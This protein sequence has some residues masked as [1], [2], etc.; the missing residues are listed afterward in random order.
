MLLMSVGVIVA[1]A[2]P[3]GATPPEYISVVNGLSTN[4]VQQNESGAYIIEA[5]NPVISF[6]GP[7][8]CQVAGNVTDVSNIWMYDDGG[9][10]IDIE[11]KQYKLL[12]LNADDEPDTFVV[13]CDY[14]NHLKDMGSLEDGDYTVQIR[15]ET[16]NI[17]CIHVFL[18]PIS[19]DVRQK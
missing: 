16:D 13:K 1:S 18:I 6:M 2:V 7:L 4:V 3:S 11:V 12:D 9:N 5:N 17:P 8:G 14:K 10:L 19:V 15:F